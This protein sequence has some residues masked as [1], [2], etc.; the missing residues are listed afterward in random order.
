[1]ERMYNVVAII[2]DRCMVNFGKKSYLSDES[3][4]MT[5][6]EACTFKSKLTSYPW[7]RVLLEEVV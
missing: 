4:P 2:E 6:K 1:M 3:K 7:R 5:H